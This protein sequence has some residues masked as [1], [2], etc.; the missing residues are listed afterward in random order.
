[1]P[2]MNKAAASSSSRSTRDGSASG[3]FLSKASNSIKRSP[4]KRHRSQL[5]NPL[6]SLDQVF[7]QAPK[8]QSSEQHP[9]P[10]NRPDVYRMHTAPLGSETT[11]PP[12]K[13]GKT[14]QSA[15]EA[16]MIVA[17]FG[18]NDRREAP[19]TLGKSAGAVAQN[20][21]NH[22]FAGYAAEASLPTPTYVSGNQNPNVL[23]HHIH[24]VASKRISTLDYFRKA[25]A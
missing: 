25:Y 21:E 14:P 17:S 20:G 23:Y 8:T 9:R 13:E 10:Q 7:Y 16:T 22:H 18:S 11:K 2:S 5:S 15:V 6:P 12:L 3:G 19:I 1:M 4:S 24:D